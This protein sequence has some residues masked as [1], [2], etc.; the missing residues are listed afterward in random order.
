MIQLWP[1][2]KSEK[3]LILQIG[4]AKPRPKN[5]NGLLPVE[6]RRPKTSSPHG[7]DIGRPGY[8]NSNTMKFTIL[9]FTS[10]RQFSS[11]LQKEK[12]IPCTRLGASQALQNPLSYTPTTQQRLRP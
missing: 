11:V 1:T 3:Q 4:R 8:R 6:L 5:T 9:A 10:F 7:V 12:K 2:I